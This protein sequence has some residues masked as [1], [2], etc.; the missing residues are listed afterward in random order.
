MPLL[1]IG[2][3]AAIQLDAGVAGEFHLLRA[4]SRGARG[5]DQI[6]VAHVGLH[7]I[8]SGSLGWRLHLPQMEKSGTTMVAPAL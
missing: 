3:V 6:Y 8:G 4:S 2:H 7:I 5:L 1:L